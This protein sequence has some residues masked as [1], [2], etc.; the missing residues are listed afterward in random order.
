MDHLEGLKVLGHGHGHCK[1][2]VDR[3]GARH[4]HERGVA[5]VRSHRGRRGPALGEVRFLTLRRFRVLRAHGDA[6]AHRRVH[7]DAR[8]GCEDVGKKVANLLGA[9]AAS[10][11]RHQGKSSRPRRLAPCHEI[12]NLPLWFLRTAYQLSISCRGVV[13]RLARRLAGGALFSLGVSFGARRELAKGDL[14]I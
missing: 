6:A 2:Q 5:D 1:V 13:G 10:W 3:L 14:I 7:A 11:T 9:H 12:I 4:L 8:V